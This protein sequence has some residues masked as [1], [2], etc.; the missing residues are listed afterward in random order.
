MPVLVIINRL[1]CIIDT[2]NKLKI[3]LINVNRTRDAWISDGVNEYKRR[4]E[5]YVVFEEL[6]VKAGKRSNHEKSKVLEE[7]AA[8]ILALIKKDDHLVLLD[9]EGQSLDSAQFSAWLNKKN[10]SLQ[11]DLVFAIGGAFG[12]DEQVLK[13]ADEKISLSRMTFTH[14]MVRLIFMEQLY[15][16]F[17]ILRN[18]PYHHA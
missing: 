4:L 17:T 3:K 13:A 6:V 7:E 11:G 1:K 5:R 15:R 2:Y 10:R 12:F 14:Q 18:E 16:G 9:G 8:K